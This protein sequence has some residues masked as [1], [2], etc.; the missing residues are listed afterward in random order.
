VPLQDWIHHWEVGGGARVVRMAASILAF[1]AIAGLYDLVS[2]QS[3]SSEEAMETAQLAR[4]IAQGEGFTTKTIRPLSMY[5]LN[6]K[7]PQEK[8]PDITNPPVYPVLLAELMK[9]APMRFKAAQFWTYQPERWIAVF[10]QALFFAAILLLFQIARRQFDDRVAWLSALLFAGTSLFWKFSVSGLSTMWVIVVLLALVLCLT[11]IAEGTAAEP[12][13]VGWSALAGL[14]VGIGGLSRYAFGWMILPVVIFLALGIKGVRGKYSTAAIACFL[15]VMG[16]WIARNVALT[17]TPFGTAGYTVIQETPPAEGDSLERSLDPRSAV[18]RV[19]IMDVVDKLLSNGRDIWRSDLPRF[20]G[21]WVTAFFLVGL[22]MPFHSP[23]RG[24]IRMFVIGSII[25]I[26]VVQA[27]GQTHLSQDSPEINS[28]NLLV[29]L[30]PLAIV[31][32]SA[33][34]FTMMDQLNIV[35]TDAKGAFVGVFLIV[36]S[37][38]LL[39]TLLVAAPP[40]LTTPYSP[41]HIQRVAGLMGEGEMMMSDIPAG[42]AWYGNHDC[43]WL[44]LDDDRE[45]FNINELRKVHALFLT[46]RTTDHR[47]LSELSA[48]PKS[49]GHLFLECEAHLEVQGYGE[50]PS[51]F[52]LTNAPAGFLPDQMLLSDHS[53]WLVRP[54]AE[55]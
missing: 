13:S 44:A 51:G 17:A 23:Q 20:G 34:F 39:L 46:Q 3:F 11:K 8:L 19:E 42:V 40:N 36:M 37:V 55:K 32:G 18:R 1:I 52:P 6:G 24:R 21:N 14:L 50:V 15:V 12:T 54:Y 35:T 41:L 48:N 2:Y 26:F 10:N 4:N 7:A 9:V 28:E 25:V 27:L 5:L 33:M 49:W 45:F 43:F 31:Y 30:A 22:L 38:P 53:R 16:P 29:L 47:F